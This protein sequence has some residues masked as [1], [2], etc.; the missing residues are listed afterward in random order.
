MVGR[1]SKR[2]RGETVDKLSMFDDPEA[3]ARRLRQAT[4]TEPSTHTNPSPG[5][6]PALN[7]S[8]HSRAVHFQ[9]PSALSTSPEAMQDDIGDQH[10]SQEHFEHMDLDNGTPRSALTHRG[11]IPDSTASGLRLTLSASTN[12]AQPPK[13]AAQ[14]QG[15][16]N[17]A[18]LHAAPAVDEAN[19]D[20]HAQ[21]PHTAAQHPHSLPQTP[22]MHAQLLD[23][24]HTA[25]LH[26]VP[27]EDD[28]MLDA[29]TTAGRAVASSQDSLRIAAERAQAIAKA[30]ALTT[31]AAAAA[32]TTT[33]SVQSHADVQPAAETGSLIP[34]TAVTSGGNTAPSD[35][36][37]GSA[38]LPGAGLAQ[39]SA[40][41][42]LSEHASEVQQLVN[43]QH[44]G[45][46]HGQEQ[47]CRDGDSTVLISTTWPNV[48][49]SKRPGGMP[50]KSMPVLHKASSSGKLEMVRLSRS[51]PQLVPHMSKATL[52]DCHHGLLGAALPG[53]EA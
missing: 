53:R 34:V 5:T 17:S 28:P 46:P 39:T 22:A 50:T 10:D 1:S 21:E 13:S 3:A 51:M 2:L 32:A 14:H 31:A 52:P 23:S 20:K 37:A 38:L 11:T 40:T 4:Q 30:Q 16:P 26:A 12:A 8:R 47:V 45:G 48:P 29:P 27:A 19:L 42:V 24:S 43:G 44:Q 49:D 18:A 41:G 36:A 6:N 33:A 9:E 35:R 15:R 7:P 25:A